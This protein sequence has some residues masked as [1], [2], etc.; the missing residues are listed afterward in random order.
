MDGAW[1]AIRQKVNRDTGEITQAGWRDKKHAVDRLAWDREQRE[2]VRDKIPQ[3]AQGLCSGPWNGR[4]PRGKGSSQERGP[5]AGR[6]V[7]RGSLRPWLAHEAAP[8]GA[9]MTQISPD[10]TTRDLV[11]CPRGGAAGRWLRGPRGPRGPQQLPRP[12]PPLPAGDHRPGRSRMAPR[13]PHSLP[14]LQQTRLV[15]ACIPAP[16]LYSN[17]A[18]PA[19]MPPLLPFPGPQDPATSSKPPP[20]AARAT[21]QRP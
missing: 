18:S 1:D 8:G 9:A 14:I 19:A 10:Q 11:R 4:V 7:R 12:L 13:G 15:A 2:E 17:A 6:Q 5:G 21:L 20:T 3:G 16:Y